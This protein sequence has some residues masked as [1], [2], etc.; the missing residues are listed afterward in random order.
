MARIL[1]MLILRPQGYK[2]HL[3]PWRPGGTSKRLLFGKGGREETAQQCS[4]A[5]HW[6]LGPVM[7]RWTW[8]IGV[9]YKD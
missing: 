8:S 7:V 6:L 3:F 9:L 5:G 1:C 4:Q 2:G